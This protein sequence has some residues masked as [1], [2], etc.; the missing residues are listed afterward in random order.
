MSQRTALIIGITGQVGAYLARLLLNNGYSVHGTS[1]DAA[2]TRL[3]G[4]T[5][6]GIQEKVTLHSLSPIDFQSVTEVIERVAPDEIYNLSGQSS[7][8]LSF[9]QPVETLEGIVFGTL[10]CSKRSVVSGP[11]PLR[12]CRRRRSEKIR[13]RRRFG[14]GLFCSSPLR[15]V[16]LNCNGTLSAAPP[17]A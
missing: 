12:R 15:A 11:M 9:S 5:A 2:F 8:A 14:S 3:E 16:P 17:P 10:I 1:R 6:L 4:L 7:V 13:R